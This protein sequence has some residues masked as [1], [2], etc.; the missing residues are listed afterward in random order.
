MKVVT[1]KPKGVA[2]LEAQRDAK[3]AAKQKAAKKRTTQAQEAAD[4]ELDRI[5]GEQARLR[6]EMYERRN[7][8]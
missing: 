2:E 6:A 7:K 3:A 1:K 5:R 8:G 4:A